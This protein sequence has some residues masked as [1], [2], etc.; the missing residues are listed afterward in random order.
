MSWQNDD[1]IQGATPKRCS[2]IY[3][4]V[5]EPIQLLYIYIYI[6]IYNYSSILYI[7]I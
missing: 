1:A 3:W 6:Y 7:Y 2:G 4:L 5:Y